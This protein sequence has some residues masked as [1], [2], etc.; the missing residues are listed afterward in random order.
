MSE[1][2]L[3]SGF[4]EGYYAAE[5]QYKSQIESLQSQLAEANAELE[6][7]KQLLG[8]LSVDPNSASSEFKPF[9]D[10][11]QRSPVYWQ[12]IVALAQDD[13]QEERKTISKLQYVVG[14]MRRDF[15]KLIG[16]GRC[17]M[18][19]QQMCDYVTG[20]CE[21]ALALSPDSL[22]PLY[23]EEEVRPLVEALNLCVELLE[24]STTVDVGTG[25]YHRSYSRVIRITDDALSTFQR[26]ERG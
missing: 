26:K 13:L 20:T 11:A 8:E 5:Q 12:E 14:E 3:N 1:L 24:R 6:R 15:D 10:R 19:H 7:H 25:D 21:E 2:D 23:T 22:P 16:F 17:D 4:N 18:G 9:F